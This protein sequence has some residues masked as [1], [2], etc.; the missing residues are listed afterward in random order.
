MLWRV[1]V[2]AIGLSSSTCFGQPPLPSCDTEHMRDS[3]AQGLQVFE[4]GVLGSNVERQYSNVASATTFTQTLPGERQPPTGAA[5]APFG[6]PTVE[7]KIDNITSASSNTGNDPATGDMGLMFVNATT[8]V[9]S[10]EFKSAKG[11]SNLEA[12]WTETHSTGEV[13]L[14]LCEARAFDAVFRGMRYQLVVDPIELKL[15][16]RQSPSGKPTTASLIRSTLAY[17]TISSDY[18]SLVVDLNRDGD[19]T[20]ADRDLFLV[21]RESGDGPGNIADFNFDNMVDDRD[22]FIFEQALKTPTTIYDRDSVGDGMVLDGAGNV[23]PDNRV[24]ARWNYE[25]TTTPK[26]EV[27]FV[28]IDAKNATWTLELNPEPLLL[29]APGGGFLPA[30]KLFIDFGGFELNQQTGSEQ[31]A[32][33]SVTGSGIFAS[34]DANS[35]SIAGP[36]PTLDLTNVLLQNG[37]LITTPRQ[38]LSEGL[39]LSYDTGTDLV[40][41]ERTVSISVSD[42]YFSCPRHDGRC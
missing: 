23:V 41:T 30:S 21:S 22:Q 31:P 9:L 16:D 17:T 24:W 4:L 18:R 12:T 13:Y 15:E 11:D 19:V 6:T 1:V 20:V 34:I 42:E 38:G 2:V 29:T 35:I 5:P 8:S 28:N 26:V 7:A 3:G 37:L 36:H 14:G 39:K 25:N 10:E 27:E 32:A 40:A 33:R